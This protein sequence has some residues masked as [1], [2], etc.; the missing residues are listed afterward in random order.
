MTQP[1]TDWSAI[2]RS[3]SKSWSTWS[4]ISSCHILRITNSERNIA[5]FVWLIAQ[6]QSKWPLMPQVR[7][8]Q[9]V[10]TWKTFCKVKHGWLTNII[11]SHGI[12]DTE[13]LWFASYFASL[14]HVVQVNGFNSHR[15]SLTS[16]VT[17]DVLPTLMLFS[18]QTKSSKLW[19]TAFFFHSPKT[20]GS[21]AAFGPRVF[22]ILPPRQTKA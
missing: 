8:W 1:I 9:S 6:L 17:K 20:P 21:F 22:V 15:R 3:P 16:G 10:W 7:W 11:Q 4:K 12:A 19:E 14:N 18:T 5:V 13:L 2:Q